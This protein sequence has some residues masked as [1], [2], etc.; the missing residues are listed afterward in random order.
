MLHTNDMLG[1][2]FMRKLFHFCITKRKKGDDSMM[3]KP[4]NRGAFVIKTGMFN[5]FVK[6]SINKK[7]VDRIYSAA[8]RFEKNIEDRKNK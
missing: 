7:D 6:E 2:G 8:S 5:K 3:T 4:R 1:R